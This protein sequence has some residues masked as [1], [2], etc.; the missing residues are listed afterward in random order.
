[1]EVCLYAY[2]LKIKDLENHIRP[3]IAIEDVKDR[4]ESDC[5]TDRKGRK[6]ISFKN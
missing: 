6:I 4:F 1:M 3:I 2:E 5:K